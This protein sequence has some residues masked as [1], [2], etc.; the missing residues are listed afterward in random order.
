MQDRDFRIHTAK[1]LTDVIL[2]VTKK[3]LLHDVALELDT[4]VPPK[5]WRDA[6]ARCNDIKES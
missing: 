5:E 2:T 1:H 6:P 3:D 4:N